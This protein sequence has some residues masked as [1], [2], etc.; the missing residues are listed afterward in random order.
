V[1]ISL[2]L[3][4]FSGPRA[5]LLASAESNAVVEMQSERL[6]HELE[7]LKQV[8][9]EIQNPELE[10]L[11]Q[12]LQKMIEQMKQP[13]LDPKEALAKLSEMEASLQQMQQQLDDPKTASEMQE[14]GEA[15]SLSEEMSNA[16]QAL[17]KGD[18]EKAADQLETLEMPKLDRQTEKAIT[19]NLDK[20]NQGNEAGAPK[21][22]SQEAASQISQGL[23]QGKS[24]KFQEG[25]K[26]LAGEARKQG[27]KK[28]LSDL[29]R[30]QCQCLSECKGECESECRNQADGKKKGGNKAGT[31][32]SGNEPGDK[33]AKLKTNPQLNLKGQESATGD[34][35]VE[36]LTGDEQQQEAVRSYREKAAE[37]EALSESVLESE[38]IPLG[39]RQTIRK[40]FQMIRPSNAETDQVNQATSEPQLAN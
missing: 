4:L 27:Q 33:T 14:I 39:H 24:G 20:L 19:E 12:N 30:K 37:Y 13:G 3:P 11:V 22:K 2:V 9:E 10:Q 6:E 15:L 29:L 7:E 16:G 25:M 28:K 26:G 21:T 1:G 34:S 17:S 23:S 32:S 38:S 5:E 36:T 31:A 8:Q 40:Y 18:F 35:E